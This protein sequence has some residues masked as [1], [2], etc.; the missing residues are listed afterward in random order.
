MPKVV[1]HYHKESNTFIAKDEHQNAVSY[2]EDR[3]APPTA[4]IA[5]STTTSPMLALL[6]SLGACTGID[7]VMILEKQRQA[8]DDLTIEITG[9]REKDATPALW[10][11]CHIKYIVKGPVELLK[12]EKAAALSVDKYCSVAATLRLAGCTITYEVI[13]M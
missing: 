5:V 4:P 7:I 3:S 8:F 9:E 11:N 10:V 12:A 1:I 13:V 6:M 2:K